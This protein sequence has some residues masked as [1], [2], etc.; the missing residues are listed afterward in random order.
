MLRI[1]EKLFLRRKEYRFEIAVKNSN[2]TEPFIAVSPVPIF[3]HFIVFQFAVQA[4]QGARHR[5]PI[6]HHAVVTGVHAV[7][8]R[9][10]RFDG[11][12]RAVGIVGWRC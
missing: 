4:G 10:I 2:S 1:F 9:E 11:C 12:A 6:Y 3:D 7:A 8:C 5:Y